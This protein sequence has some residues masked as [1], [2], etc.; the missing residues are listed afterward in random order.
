MS[1]EEQLKQLEAVCYTH[2][3]RRELDE[4]YTMR[5][6]NHLM[7]SG[8]L[9]AD[10]LRDQIR[11]IGDDLKADGKLNPDS[12]LTV[13]EHTSDWINRVNNSEPKEFLLSGGVS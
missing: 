10:S 9:S 11:Q 12:S 5:L 13:D 3:L 6:F 2:K 7:Q 1:T 8:V 4:H